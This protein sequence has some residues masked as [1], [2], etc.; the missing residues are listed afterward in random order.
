[1][2]AFVL[3]LAI[4]R[5]GSFGTMGVSLLGILAALLFGVLQ[6]LPP[7]AYPAQI[8]LYLELPS[9]LIVGALAFWKSTRATSSTTVTSQTPTKRLGELT[10]LHIELVLNECTH[11][12]KAGQSILEMDF[13][14]NNPS[15][16][17]T[18]IREVKGWIF[19]HS[20]KLEAHLQ[21]LWDHKT[22]DKI[23]QPYDP[24]KRPPFEQ[25]NLPHPLGAHATERY[26]A[27]LVVADT[28]STGQ[29]T[30]CGIIVKHTH[31]EE[32]CEGIS[33]P[34][35]LQ[36]ISGQETSEEASEPRILL[37]ENTFLLP[38]IIRFD[39]EIR[40]GEE[41][42][43]ALE[44]QVGH[45]HS[46]S[47]IEWV[48]VDLRQ[49][50][51]EEVEKG[52]AGDP[53]KRISL[54]SHDIQRFTFVTFYVI[55]PAEIRFTMRTLDPNKQKKFTKLLWITPFFEVYA[56]FVGLTKE[57]V[58]RYVVVYNKPPWGLNS[59]T[60]WANPH[61]ELVEADSDRGKQLLAEWE[62][63]RKELSEEKDE[64]H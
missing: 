41:K 49:Y 23:R 44:V 8:I 42:I 63:I 35:P 5:M 37:N 15:D 59:S 26:V 22:L 14:L 11:Y 50:D 2:I 3:I 64:S 61:V 43:D 19:V 27:Y 52:K 31:N 9:V 62:K 28:I 6:T 46:G 51:F 24:Q 55:T 32:I 33:H 7:G 53:I 16:Y 4:F 25:L 47:P 1:M 36:R 38:P 17:Q 34:S 30:K 18:S 13:E 54:L 20:R 29:D 48:N 21:T 57:V 45:G 60:G 10:E 40:A 39:F 56:R 58:K 12:R